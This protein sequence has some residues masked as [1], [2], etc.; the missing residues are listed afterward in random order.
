MR[1]TLMVNILGYCTCTVLLLKKPTFLGMEQ[2]SCGWVTSH[3]NST[4]TFLKS[5][6]YTVMEVDKGC[7]VSESLE[8]VFFVD[9][10]CTLHPEVP[11]H[12]RNGQ[13]TPPPSYKHE[14]YY[15]NSPICSYRKDFTH[16]NRN[17]SG[18][19]NLW[20]EVFALFLDHKLSGA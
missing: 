11:L 9:T 16:T 8:V 18:S 13:K 10:P 15:E 19:A 17:I 20:G 4:Q 1:V 14:G 7:C 2:W 3:F 6:K 12:N 5:T